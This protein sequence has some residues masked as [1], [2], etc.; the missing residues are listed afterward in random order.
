MTD[1]MVSVSEGKKVSIRNPKATRPWQHVLEPLSGYLQ[2]GQKLLEEKVEFS[3]AWNF[4]PS[5]EGSICV[6]EVVL[7]VKQHWDKIDYEISRDPNQLHEANLLKLDCSKAHIKL[8]WKDAWESE[9]T[10]EKTVKW[11]RAF[12][13]DNTILTQQDLQSYIIDAT[14][15]KIEWAI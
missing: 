6:E 14:C 11:Y 7:H 13:E 10:F 15:K 12:Y 3:E 4:G 9:T 1:I 8:H 5:D 2:V